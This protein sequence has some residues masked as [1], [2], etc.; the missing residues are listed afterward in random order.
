[1]RCKQSEKSGR[2]PQRLGE[3]SDLGR[4]S[5]SPNLQKHVVLNDGVEVFAVI[6]EVEALFRS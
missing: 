3:E 2:T 5:S 4:L 1:M 6:S